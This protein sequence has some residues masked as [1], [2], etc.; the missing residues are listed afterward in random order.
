MNGDK[1]DAPSRQLKIAFFIGQLDGG[2]AERQLALLARGLIDH[3][4][5]VEIW[6]YRAGGQYEELLGQASRNWVVPILGRK[7]GPLA[8]LM[9]VRRK[10]RATSADI[11]F[12]YLEECCVFVTLARRRK[13]RVKVAWGVR[14]SGVRA[15][16]YPLKIGILQYFA[17]KMVRQADLVVFNSEEGR[18]LYSVVPTE[19]SA[20]VSNGIETDRFLPAESHLELENLRKEYGVPG[21]SEVVL[22]VGRNDP[23]KAFDDF[24]QVAAMVLRR[25]PTCQFLVAGINREEF[26]GVLE[27]EESFHFYGRVAQPE[28]LMKI[29]DVLLSTSK[30][31]EGFSNVLAEA[32]ACG[33]RVVATDV[34]SASMI[35]GD[36]GAVCAPGDVEGLAHEVSGQLI[37]KYSLDDKWETNSFI[38][39]QY[40]VVKMVSSTERL[41]LCL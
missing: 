2:G 21:E 9:A 1:Q 17:K 27:Y 19:K 38:R 6:V 15:S 4:H 25:H 5:H 28:E 12:P 30:Y 34:G 10:L 35:V 3:G 29:S 32:L 7:T 20:V 8:R 14:N 37:A 41:L 22:F 36:R 31:G 24:T 39:N 40:G 11:V 26:E 16:D 18:R 33:A 23:M 13:S